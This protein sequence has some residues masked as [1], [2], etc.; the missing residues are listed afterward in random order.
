MQK[1]LMTMLAVLAFAL[2]ALADTCK[3]GNPECKCGENCKCTAE[4]CECA[5]CNNDAKDA[6]VE[7]DD[8]CNFVSA[9]FG[10]AFDS[11]Y[12]TYGVVDGKDPILTPSAEICFFDTLYFGVESIFDLTRGNGKRGGYGKRGGEWTT[13]DAI[14]G[15]RHDFDLGED[16]G[17]LSVDV[18]YIYE[19]IRRYMSKEDSDSRAVDDTQY[20]NLELSLGDL[21]LEPTLAIERDIMAD[22]GTYVNLELGHTFTV[23]GDEEDPVVTLRPAVGQGFGDRKRTYGYFNGSYQEH[24]ETDKT[25][26]HAGLMDTSV[27]LTAEWAVCDHVT[28]SGYVACSDY[29]FDRKM[30]HAARDYNNDWTTERSDK[31]DDSFQVVG[32]LALALDF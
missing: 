13:L 6:I 28:L 15:L 20:V 25:Y 22:N 19:Y 31:Y 24:N 18:N 27:S 14:V 23:V 26:D 32:G 9:S 30:R 7:E 29:L 21:W 1:K 2:S 5:G 17:A 10:L 11:K 12:L 3:C 8:E 4:K 16:L